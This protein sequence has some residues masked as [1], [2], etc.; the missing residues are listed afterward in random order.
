MA[1]RRPE[2]SLVV[3]TYD[4]ARELPRTLRSL[5]PPDHG[6]TAEAV[7]VISV[8]NGSTIPVAVALTDDLA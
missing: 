2:L 5:P 1:P 4:Q 7:E 6:G 3:V 8:D